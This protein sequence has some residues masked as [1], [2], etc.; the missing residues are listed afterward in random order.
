MMNFEYSSAELTVN[1]VMT[2]K[3]PRMDEIICMNAASQMKP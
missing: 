3:P 1:A 2:E